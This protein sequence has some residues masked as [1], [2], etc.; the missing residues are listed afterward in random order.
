MTKDNSMKSNLEKAAYHEA[1]HIV[2]AVK[3]CGYSCSRS[4][5]D[6]NGGGQSIIH[7]GTEHGL[8]DMLSK[9]CVPKNMP[10]EDLELLID[11]K[12]LII[13]CGPLAEY[14]N[15]VGFGYEGLMDVEFSGSDMTEF[16]GIL[17]I[18]NANPKEKLTE[19]SLLFKCD[20][21]VEPIHRIA[22]HLMQNKVINEEEINKCIVA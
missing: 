20:E 12:S 11:K 2:A 13:A 4:V 5:I 18:N 1:G 9:G 21:F 17:S 10:Y 22:N 15:N 19:I 14:L 16:E 8:Y 3:M 7:F 6:D